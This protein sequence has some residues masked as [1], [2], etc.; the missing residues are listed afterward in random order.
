VVNS[1]HGDVGDCITL[2]D[3]WTPFPPDRQRGYS[4]ASTVP[5][6]TTVVNYGRGV[7]DLV[8]VTSPVANEVTVPGRTRI[9]LGRNVVIA[10]DAGQ[11]RSLLVF[12]TGGSRS[13]HG[14]RAADRA[15][16][17]RDLATCC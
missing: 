11:V 5:V 15:E 6:V 1:A 4:A 8:A 12:G 16:H 9:P 2:R 7:D 3:V 14:R 10:P 17:T 13:H